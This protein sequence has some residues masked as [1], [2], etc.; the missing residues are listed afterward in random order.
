[1]TGRRTTAAALAAATAAA[2]A[3]AA[4]AAATPLEGACGSSPAC[5]P[6]Q[7]L[8]LAANRAA[9]PVV[10]AVVDTGV[11][12]ATV[13]AGRVLHGWSALGAAPRDA[14]GHGTQ[15]AGIV[16]AVCRSCRIL[17]VQVAGADGSATDADIAAGIRWAAD[18]GARVINVSLA[19]PCA[20]PVLEQAIRY[21]VAGGALVVAAGNAG[22][23]DPT[24]CAA[25]CGGYPAAYAP[26]V[27][28]LVSVGATG[29][30]GR[31]LP[32]SNRGSW[33]ELAAPGAAVAPTLDGGT[34]AVWPGTSYAAAYVSGLAALAAGRGAGRPPAELAA[35][36][37][38]TARLTGGVRVADARTLLARA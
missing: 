29:A 26:H 30:D 17:P 4:G 33:V 11:A 15:V 7:Q 16:G 5:W 3:L 35:L 32:T 6:A 31:L 28:G 1:M 22:S 19:G 27:P 9:S 14:N 23:D 13:L 37:R 24:A 36:L 12:P 34:A 8:R 10:V 20:D 2:A 25:E 21:A 38:S 18:H